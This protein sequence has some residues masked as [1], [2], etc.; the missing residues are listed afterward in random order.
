MYDTLVDC[1][2][3]VKEKSATIDDN[4][5]MLNSQIRSNNYFE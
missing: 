2:T 1:A 4:T 5:Q 3:L